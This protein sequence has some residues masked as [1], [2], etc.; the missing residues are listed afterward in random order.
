VSWRAF[1]GVSVALA[2]PQSPRRTALA[3]CSKGVIR[4]RRGSIL[5]GIFPSD[6]D[7]LSVELAAAAIA[8][9]CSSCLAR[10]SQAVQRSEGGNKR[11]KAP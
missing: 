1:P 2:M 9:A 5:S 6:A 11:D 8:A 3:P 7:S 4:R 10:G